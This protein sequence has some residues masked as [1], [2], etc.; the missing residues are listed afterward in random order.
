MSKMYDLTGRIFNNLTVLNYAGKRP[1][2]KNYWLC[3]CVCG[4]EIEVESGALLHKGQ[5]S[6][7][8]LSPVTPFK[9]YTGRRFGMLVAK[10]FVRRENK[11]TYWSF[12]CDCGTEKVLNMQ[13]V[14]NDT[15]RSCGCLLKLVERSPIN[16]DRDG[17]FL[18]T[19]SG[20]IRKGADKRNIEYLL[21]IEDLESI[22]FEPC[23]YC[24]ATNSSHLK[25]TKNETILHN[26]V[27]RL[28]SSLGYVPDNCVPCCWK[29]NRAKGSLGEKDFLE[30]IEKVYNYRIKKG[31]S[32][33]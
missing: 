9:D 24:G 7:G 17:V 19:L 12:I 30:W 8:C 28:D 31:D 25:I 32:N 22:V 15:T 11:R 20:K 10:S 1:N 2:K 21:E 6:C 3:R 5:F 33:G 14:L 23:Y 18:R 26:G 4:K 29:C 27:D 16:P 13:N